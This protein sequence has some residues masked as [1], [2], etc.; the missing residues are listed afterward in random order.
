MFGRKPFFAPGVPFHGWDFPPCNIPVLS[1]PSLIFPRR[2]G[3]TRS[4]SLEG[5]PRH[6]NLVPSAPPSL[7]RS[8]LFIKGAYLPLFS[9]TQGILWNGSGWRLGYPCIAYA[10][11]VHACRDKPVL[12]NGLFYN[13]GNL[14]ILHLSEA[15]RCHGWVHRW[16]PQTGELQI[17]PATCSTRVVRIQWDNIHKAFRT[18]PGTRW[19]LYKCLVLILPFCSVVQLALSTHLEKGEWAGS[20]FTPQ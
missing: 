9:A 11:W 5:K 12:Q 18:A 19:M 15:E 7:P 17:P 3:L 14:F 6:M 10:W 1:P 8:G 4:V 13:E 16:W 20:P 2:G